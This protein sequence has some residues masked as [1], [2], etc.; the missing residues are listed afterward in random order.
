MA[1]S[2]ISEKEAIAAGTKIASESIMNIR[3]VASLRK[4]MFL[5]H[6]YDFFET[7]RLIDRFITST[8]QEK[9]MINRF[10]VEMERVEKLA[11]KKIFFRGLVNSFSQAV[12]FLA[13]T[14]ALCYGGFMVAY[15]EIHY[16]N[17]VRY[18]FC[19]TT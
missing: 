9:Q 13:Y 1:K 16:K 8:G 12:P 7:S 19:F 18:V 14:V 15:G 5:F 10:M 3:T 17:I 2:A 4:N 6:F 11:F